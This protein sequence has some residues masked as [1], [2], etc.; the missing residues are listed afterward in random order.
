[1]SVLASVVELEMWILL[2]GLTLVIAFKLLDG[3]IPT[4]GMLSEKGK[5]EFSP[6]RL[7]L[8]IASLIGALYY[9]LQALGP[10]SGGRL[11]D[12]PEEV[13]LALGGSN[14]L[15]LGAKSLPLIGMSR[16]E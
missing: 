5:G 14:M 16:R 12:I 1:M 6:A 8:L 9:L 13:L 10:E 7:Q 4:R 15:Y 11:P 2:L 3:K